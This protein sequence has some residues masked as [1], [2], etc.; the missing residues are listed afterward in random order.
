MIAHGGCQRA[1]PFSAQRGEPVFL[2]L[3]L[4]TGGLDPHQH[5]ILEM[6]V[7]P[8][9]W[10]GA[11]EGEVW[12]M[13]PSR[14]VD[15]QALATSGLSLDE[16][17]QAPPPGEVFPQLLARLEG[18]LVVAHNAP[19]DQAFLRVAT[20]ELG[21]PAP[22]IRWVDILALARLLWP[23]LSSH[24]LDALCRELG[25]PR[26]GHRAL[27]D[28]RAAGQL[29]LAALKEIAGWAGEKWGELAPTLP[30]EVLALARSYSLE[31]DFG[32]LAHAPGWSHRPG[33]RAYANRVAEALARGKLVLL[34]AGPGTGKTFG[35]LI[36]LLRWLAREGGRAV[37]S[38]RTR[39]LQ[40]QLWEHD[41]PFL[42]SQLGLP[43]PVALL[44]GRENYL[45]KQRLEE[46]RGKLVDER[47]LAV[48]VGWSR[49][50]QS[51]DL[52]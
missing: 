40:S 50:T 4:E 5:D 17:S 29:F 49:R 37:V 1:E 27:P 35:Y 19:F 8:F 23:C 24:S 51:G 12:L 31:Q 7:V 34:E 33:Q 45:C 30:P 14:P 2:A 25:L 11:G 9:S 3:D 39:A 44:K 21:L 32:K 43:L 41:L 48:L 26:P 15:P 28:A 20:E 52:D 18:Q 10:E 16:L 22:R 38:T 47:A 42:L 6:A 36:P 46:L 13:R